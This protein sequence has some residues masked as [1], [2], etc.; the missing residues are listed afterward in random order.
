MVLDDLVHRAEQI[1]RD[2]FPGEN[3][4]LEIEPEG[5]VYVVVHTRRSD[6]RKALS[7]ADTIWLSEHPE[8]AARIVLTIDHQG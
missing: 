4:V 2:Q 5:A 1:L 6:A 3:V 7:R 8:L